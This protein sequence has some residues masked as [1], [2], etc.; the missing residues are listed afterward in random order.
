MPIWIRSMKRS[1]NQ[2]MGGPAIPCTSCGLR[3]PGEAGALAKHDEDAF[4][5][6]SLELGDERRRVSDAVST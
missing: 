1:L 3:Q 4:S 6:G 5:R 2:G